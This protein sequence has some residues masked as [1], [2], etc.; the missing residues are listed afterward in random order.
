MVTE[1][2]RLRECESVIEKGVATFMDVG[3]ALAEI[4]DKK[5]YRDS[6]KVFEDYVKERWGHGR[7]WAYQLIGA[8]AAAQ[9]VTDRIHSNP[10]AP[11]LPTPNRE[12]ARALA[13]IPSEKQAEAWEE[14]TSNG[15]PTGA[16][17]EAARQRISGGVTF[18]VGEIERAAKEKKKELKNGQPIVGAKV[19]KECLSLHGKLCRA[20]QAIGVYDEF[21]EPLSQIATRLRTL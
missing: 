19:R 18:D 3:R 7:A 17:V 16:K 2:A 12:Q 11:K 20:L 1:T 4:R 13:K 14:A 9:N 6:H 10:K 5:L 15:K 21:I 8:S